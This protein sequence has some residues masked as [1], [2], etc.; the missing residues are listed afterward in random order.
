MNFNSFNTRF[1][2]ADASSFSW[3]GGSL[4]PWG[5]FYFMEN[6]KNISFEDLPGERW[7]P[8][9]KYEGLYQVSSLGRVKSLSKKIGLRNRKNPIILKQNLDV[10]GYP[11]ILLSKN[12]IINAVKVHR[13]VADAFIPNLENKPTVNH[14]LGIK[15]DNRASELEWLTVSEQTKHSYAVLKRKLSPSSFKRGKDHKA[16]KPVI[17]YT[18]DG[19]FIKRYAS[20]REAQRETGIDRCVIMNVCREIGFYKTAGGFKWEYETNIK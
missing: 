18:R 4:L 10:Y 11:Q 13:L 8:I 16:S 15:T 17:Q 2:R 3:A 1:P 12:G 7:R 20:V 5:F 19:V 6:Y 9:K 14:K